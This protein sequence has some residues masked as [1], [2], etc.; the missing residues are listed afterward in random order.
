MSMP[1]RLVGF[2]ATITIYSIIFI[3]NIH[4]NLDISSVKDISDGPLRLPPPH[5]EENY[6]ISKLRIIAFPHGT[7]YFG[8]DSQQAKIP[9][10][11]AFDPSASW[12]PLQRE[13]LNDADINIEVEK[14][15]CA[16]YNFGFPSNATLP[17]KR[18]RLFYGAMI[19]GDSAEVLKATSTEQYNIYH[20]VSL[21]ESNSTHNLSPKKWR[22]FGSENATKELHWLYQLYGPNTKVS[23]DYYVTSLSSVNDPMYL[24]YYQREGIAFRWKLNGMRPDDIAIVGDLDETY[25]RDFLRALQICDV[26]QFRP[27]QTC[28][29]PKVIASTLMFE[30]SP[31]CA[32]KERRW[33]HPG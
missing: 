14:K 19:S 10:S 5:V 1:L 7:F 4:S 12:T 26:P 8:S 3:A 29:G 20:T 21:I 6:D 33:Y 18:R 17:L 25:S 9:K 15:R 32:W 27:G 2:I 31:E 13:L 11:D 28:R 23:M 24:D 16:S 22:F 30:S